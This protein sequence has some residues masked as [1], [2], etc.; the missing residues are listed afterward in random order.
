MDVGSDWDRQFAAPGDSEHVNPA[1]LTGDLARLADETKVITTWAM[2]VLAHLD[3]HKPLIVPKYGKIRLALAI[4]GEIANHYE[5][6]FRRSEHHW[7]DPWF[8]GDWQAMFR[9]A[10]FALTND[11]Y[12]WPRPGGYT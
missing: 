6:M 9:P 3:P 11:V 12:A 1:L 4:A 2:K 7:G 8:Q 10:L 5:S